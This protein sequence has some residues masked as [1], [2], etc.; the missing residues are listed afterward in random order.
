MQIQIF[1][2]FFGSL[3]Y[4]QEAVNSVLSQTDPDW[5]LIVVDDRY[6]SDAP[7]QWLR[8]I[9]DSRIQ[10]TRNDTNL[11][12]TGNFN[13][14]IELSTADWVVLMGGDDKLLANFVS[15]AKL[16]ISA[17]PAANIIQ[18]GVQVIN[19]LSE[20]CNPLA[21]RIKR[22]LAPKKS[23][24]MELDSGAALASLMRGNWLYF[25]SLVWK[26]EAVAKYGFD[27]KYSIVQDLN[28]IVKML[29]D[30]GKLAVGNEGSFQYRRHQESLSSKGGVTGARYLEEGRF[31]TEVAPK[32]LSE[33]HRIA[34]RRARQHWTSRMAAIVD[35][36]R[37]GATLANDDKRTLFHHI[38]RR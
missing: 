14:C 9:D 21:D 12:V 34:S 6:P 30:G 8:S 32:L 4:L 10:Y 27:A 17:F 18:P 33:G 26:R 7:A 37:G 28:L 35:L 16:L 31:F 38:F 1:I 20:V 15:E 23:Q 11:G 29:L 5:Q 3:N 22:R 36:V 2:P 25:P 13:R 19:G 24:P